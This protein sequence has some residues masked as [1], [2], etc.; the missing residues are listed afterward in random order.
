MKIKRWILLVMLM[1]IF[2]ILFGCGKKQGPAPI[3]PVPKTE[4]VGP[5]EF[6]E[7]TKLTGFYM[8]HMG[9]RMAPYYIL[10]TTE[11]GTYMKITDKCPDDYWMY[12]DVNVEALVQPAQYF[13]HVETIL[14]NEYASLVRLEEETIIRQ[15]EECIVKYGALGWDGYDKSEAMPGVLDSGD[16]YNLYL[17]LSDG[18]TVTMHGYNICPNGFRELYQDVVGIF[19]EHSDYSRY[20]ARS[21]TDSPCEYLQV[22]LKDSE[23]PYACFKLCLRKNGGEWSVLLEDEAGDVLEKGT[24]IAEYAATGKEVPFQRFLDLMSRYQV[25]EW[26]GYQTPGSGIG[27]HFNI[28]MRFEDGT[29]FEARGSEFPEGYEAFKHAFVKEIYDFYM[30]EQFGVKTADTTLAEKICG[31]YL[32]NDEYF[33]EFRYMDDKLAAEVNYQKDFGSVYSRHMVE[34]EPEV[35]KILESVTEKTLRMTGREFSGFSKE[36][37][38]WNEEKP[39]VLTVIYEGLSYQMEG[40]DTI[41]LLKRVENVPKMHDEDM[42]KTYFGQIV[43]ASQVNM[44]NSDI[45]GEWYAESV[46]DGKK[47]NTYLKFEENGMMWFVRKTDGEPMEQYRCVYGVSD[48]NDHMKIYVVGERSG[49]PYAPLSGIW[50]SVLSFR[51]LKNDPSL[52]LYDIDETQSLQIGQ[53]KE[54]V[55]EFSRER[56]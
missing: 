48:E 32:Y 35:D 15:L 8:N 6:P 10:K 3:D 31:Y 12:K 7:G 29:K 39:L 33:I 36:G 9:M 34:L 53:T 22:D 2:S 17:E 14:E 42:L 25:E 43:D 16:N 52:K 5:I 18:T 46:K 23:H 55:L 30:E 24:K 56:K 4:E 49:W 44:E 50:Q 19:E 47:E 20:M 37:E 45:L 41:Y 13:A 27:P 21:F 51:D 54:G 28:Y 1:G 26:N 11:S 38:Y 40:S